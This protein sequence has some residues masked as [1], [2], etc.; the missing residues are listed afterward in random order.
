VTIWTDVDG[1]FSA[2]PHRVPDAV[3]VP[4]LSY[5]EAAELAYFGAK[6]IHPNTMSPAI[7]K[8]TLRDDKVIPNKDFVLRYD[9]TGKRVEDAILTHRDKRGGFFTFDRTQHLLRTGVFGG[10]TAHRDS[11][12]TSASRA[13]E[14]ARGVRLHPGVGHDDHGV[15]GRNRIGIGIR[16]EIEGHHRARIAP[17][18]A[19][20]PFAHLRGVEARADPHDIDAPRRRQTLGSLLSGRP[21]FG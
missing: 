10:Q 17:G 2:D 5:Q 6:V 21:A 12:R 19:E 7:A 3:V 9:V 8:V 1:V 13:F 11:D 20:Q 18:G 14:G 16:G 15:V 4:E